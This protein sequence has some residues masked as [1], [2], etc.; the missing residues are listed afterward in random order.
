M[1][2][3]SN[4]SELPLRLGDVYFQSPKRK[5]REY[6]ALCGSAISN[7]HGN[8]A[9]GDLFETLK[10]INHK[11]TGWGNQYQFCNNSELMKAIDVKLEGYIRNLF[12]AFADKVKNS[13]TTPI[14]NMLGMKKISECKKSP[15]IGTAHQPN[16]I[17]P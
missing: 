8:P 6:N 9:N 4:C 13:Q 10:V 12:L 14:Q 17:M 7:I 15:I 2:Y 11:I 5:T 1:S 16:S 3:L